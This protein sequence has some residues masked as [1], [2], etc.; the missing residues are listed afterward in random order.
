MDELRKRYTEAGDIFVELAKLD[1]DV[2]G[3]IVSGSLTYGTLDQ[4]S[5]IDIYLVL[6][7]S[8]SYRERGNIWIN[9][10]EI[11]YFKNPPQQ[12]ESYFT[13]EKASPHTAHMLAFGKLVYYTS[14]W[15]PELIS[16]AKKIIETK[17]AHF[18]QVQ[19]ELE[20]YFLDDH[21]K[22][23]DDALI[24]EDPL[25]TQII[26]A[27]IVNRCIDI[28]YTF[29]QKRRVKDKRIHKDLETLDPSFMTLVSQSMSE[30]WNEQTAILQLKSAIEKLLGGPRSKEWKLRSNL[31]L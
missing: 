20:K 4:N 13:K 10:I 2:I 15:V 9:D 14:N 21:F 5:D 31:D 12:I 16:K 27:K 23:L 11:E 22:D 17:P 8:C 26:K 18:N 1:H 24:N 25:G 3:I 30:K 19:V 29:H 28:Y 7:P 6:D